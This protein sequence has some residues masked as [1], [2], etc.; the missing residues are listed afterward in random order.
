MPFKH[1]SI[2]SSGLSVYSIFEREVDVLQASEQTDNEHRDAEG[3]DEERNH[4]DDGGVVRGA[5]EQ[6]RE[7][8]KCQERTGQREDRGGAGEDG[9]TKGGDNRERE[10][11]GPREDFQQSFHF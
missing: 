6:E 9:G 5:G 10:G 4:G 1:R 7:G 8:E 11:D 3:T 2:V